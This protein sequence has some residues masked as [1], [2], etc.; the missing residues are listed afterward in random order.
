MG[1]VIGMMKRPAGRFW[2]DTFFARKT[3][4]RVPNRD[5]TGRTI[6]F[7]GGTDGMGRAAVGRFA[8]MGAE[9]CLLGRDPQKTRR[10]VDDLAGHRGPFSIVECDIGSLEQ[11]RG[12]ADQV[13]ARHER[14]DCLINCA[15]V[16][17][18]ERRLSADGYEMN[19]AVN[20]LGPFLLTELLLERVRSTPSARIINLTSATQE[21]A[22]LNLDGLQLETGWSQLQSYAQAKLCVIMHGRDLARRLEDSGASVNCLNP[23]YIRT[24]I[25]RGTSGSASLF[26]KLFGGLAAPTWVGGE[27]ILAAALDRYYEGVSGK[28]IYEDMLLDPNPLALDDDKVARLMDISRRMTGLAAE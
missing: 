18:P 28:Y 7:T 11:V 12:A 19:F 3:M 26:S 9:I 2:V 25:S 17:A 22:K 14:I 24:N 1:F 16:S 23:G 13:L 20:Y 10:V 5:L 8:E 21:V 27:R 15:G 6:V 4:D